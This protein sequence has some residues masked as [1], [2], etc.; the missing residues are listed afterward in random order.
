MSVTLVNRLEAALDIRISTVKLIQGPSIDQLVD[1][2]FPELA[3]GEGEAVA[4]PTGAAPGAAAGAWLVVVGPRPAPRFRLFCFPFAGGGS[5][6]YRNWAQSLDPTI[7]VVAIEPPGRLSRIKENPVADV[8]EF[9]DKLVSEMHDLL[10]RPFAFFGHCLGGLT[11][12]ETA[13]RLVHSTEFQPC[14][15]FASGARPPDRIA[16]Q[17]SFEERLTRDLLKLAEF[18]INLP[19]YAQPDDVFAE[20]IRHFNIG[21]TEQLLEDPQLRLLMLPVI[22]AE[23]QMANKY[24]FVPEPPWEIPITCFAAR[25]DPYVSRRHALGWGRFTNSRLQVHIRPGAHFAV[26]DDAAFIH[27]MI[28]RELLA[29]G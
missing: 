4:E 3:G 19:P 14:H 22:R 6:V 28:N 24:E 15:L 27:G 26:V 23:F 21:A 9:V 29:A 17:G 18:R 12:Y 10:D 7:E 1:D 20:L 8:N 2:I 13:R 25:G 11:M 5:A 16:D